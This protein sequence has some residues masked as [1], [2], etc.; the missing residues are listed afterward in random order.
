MK[1]SFLSRRTFILFCIIIFALVLVAK[2]FLVQVVHGNAYKE[3]ADRQYATPSGNIYERGTI[4][5][6]TK[7]GQLVSGAT[8]TTGFKLAIDPNKIVDA[9]ETY[10]KLSQIINLD[11]DKF[12]LIASKK[13]D[14]YEEIANHLSKDKADAVTALKIPGLNIF[15]EKWRFYPGGILA[16]HQLGLVGYIGAVSIKRKFHVILSLPSLT[17]TD[18][19]PLITHETQPV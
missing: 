11:H 14:P 9:E 17:T 3:E 2:L 5:F 8:Q 18:L 10:Q 19:R 7:N 15:K 12:I 16:S 1:F 4:Y 6:E 13:D